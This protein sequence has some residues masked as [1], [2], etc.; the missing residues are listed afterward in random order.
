MLIASKYCKGEYHMTVGRESSGAATGKCRKAW[1]RPVF[2]KAWDRPEL[3]KLDT[4]GAE[5]LQK[6]ARDGESS[7]G[8]LS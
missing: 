5:F 7:Q 6:K 1:D 3:R 2:R 8:E 4:S